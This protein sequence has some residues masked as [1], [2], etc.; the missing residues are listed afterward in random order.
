M[1]LHPIAIC[2]IALC[3]LTLP[4]CTKAISNNDQQPNTVSPP[5]ESARL[6]V[7]E[8]ES[9]VGLARRNITS[10]SSDILDELLR[11][12]GL[13]MKYKGEHN[14]LP[15]GQAELLR[16]VDQPEDAALLKLYKKLEFMDD[17]G[18]TSIKFERVRKDSDLAQSGTVTIGDQG[19]KQ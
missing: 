9:I 11:V 8:G 10:D 3:M 13:A 19:A 6:T 18:A 4:S 1:H 2:A 5:Q 14:T 12:Y 16:F 15:S 17:Q 7:L